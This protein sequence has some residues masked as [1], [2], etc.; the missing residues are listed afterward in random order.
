MPRAKKSTDPLSAFIGLLAD[1]LAAR[2]DFPPRASS[3]ASARAPPAGAAPT[4]AGARRPG[5][6]GSAAQVARLT[7]E[8]LDALATR[9][10]FPPRASSAAAAL[11]APAGAAAPAGGRRKGRKRSPAPG[12][13]LADELLAHVRSHPGERIDQI[14]SALRTTTR[15]LALPARKL[16]LQGKIRTRDVKQATRYY[17]A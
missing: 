4:R 16:L 5:R 10:D 2:L 13:R 7:D 15:E 3:A 8:L 9:L 1:A 12:A 14:A 17:G 6:K 11:A